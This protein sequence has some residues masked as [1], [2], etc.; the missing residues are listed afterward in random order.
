V[1][2]RD[3]TYDFVVG[4]NLFGL[5]RSIKDLRSEAR[6]QGSAADLVITRRWRGWWH[7]PYSAVYAAVRPGPSRSRSRCAPSWDGGPVGSGSPC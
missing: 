1:G 2:D 5:F 7:R 4:V 3:A 6:R